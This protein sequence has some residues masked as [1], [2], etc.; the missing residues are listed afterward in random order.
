MEWHK[1]PIQDSSL[2]PVNNT[3][4]FHEDNATSDGETVRTRPTSHNLLGRHPPNGRFARK[5]TIPH[6]HLDQS[7]SGFLNT[8]KCS[9][10]PCRVIDFLGFLFDSCI[11]KLFLPQ[12]KVDQI[13]KE[14]H[15]M[16][17]KGYSSA[18]GPAHLIGLLIV[19]IHACLPALLHYR[20]L[21]RHKYRALSTTQSYNQQV[22]LD[23]DPI[24]DLQFWITEI[25][26]WN[27]RPINLPMAD[28]TI[29]SDAS[30]SGW[31]ASCGTSQTHQP[32]RVESS[33]PCPSDV[34]IQTE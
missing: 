7:S 32:L 18:R 26:K 33:L 24:K 1:L 9:L 16:L 19:T 5:I 14:Y 28:L 12:E 13:K 17:K 22:D 25:H 11:M 3:L 8:K 29:T 20:G 6:S 30:T 10:E 31:G 23:R 27:G 21:Q 34:H 4:D 2:Q 15:S